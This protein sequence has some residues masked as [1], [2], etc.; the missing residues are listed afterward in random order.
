LV[1]GREYRICFAARRENRSQDNNGALDLAL[2]VAASTSLRD[3][4]VAVQLAG[5][6]E[7]RQQGTSRRTICAHQRP[8]NSDVAN[9]A[10]ALR[11]ASR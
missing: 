8:A 3:Q 1:F 11:P 4:L 6:I 5:E 10:L 7:T 9:M 2:V